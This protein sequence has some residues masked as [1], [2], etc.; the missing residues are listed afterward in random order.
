MA[1][2][3]RSAA[4]GVLQKDHVAQL[5]DEYRTTPNITDPIS[6]K[7]FY[8]A[9]ERWKNKARKRASYARTVKAEKAMLVP[10]ASAEAAA[11]LE[12]CTKQLV[13]LTAVIGKVST[14]VK[15]LANRDSKL[16]DLL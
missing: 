16:K 2:N 14:V 11:L 10:G 6:Y 15:A 7:G 12:N 5:Y 1:A 9:Y 13:D 4:D 3:A 8:S